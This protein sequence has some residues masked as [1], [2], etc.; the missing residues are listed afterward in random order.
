MCETKSAQGMMPITLQDGTRLFVHVA[1]K[2]EHDLRGWRDITDDEGNVRGGEQV[3]SK[4]GLGAMAI[5][6]REGA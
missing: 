3:C 4:C 5:S 6:L 2:C 1:P